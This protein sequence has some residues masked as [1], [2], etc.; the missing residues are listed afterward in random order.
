MHTILELRTVMHRLSA[1][2]REFAQSL[3]A[4][5]A[6]RSEP[7]SKQQTWIDT[8]YGRA[9]DDEPG[10][11]DLGDSMQGLITLFDKAAENLKRPSITIDVPDV[12]EVKLSLAGPQARCPGTINV[13]DK[14]AFGEGVFYGRIDRNGRFDVR[15][16]HPA[17][18]NFL[19]GF[20]AD[21]AKVAGAH[22]RRT[23][24]CCFCATP[25]KSGASL[26]VGY[27]PVCAARFQLPWG[28]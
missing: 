6:A 4:S 1:S 13:A 22:G 18:V 23:G 21:P 20:A 5:A 17:L 7:T 11:V 27:G 25:I 3:C 26:A 10:A 8:L 2:D 15:G 28:E 14:A 12:G 16:D 9:T 19:K 24:N